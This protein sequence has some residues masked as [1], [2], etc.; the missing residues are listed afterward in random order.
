MPR[1]PVV[2]LTS[3]IDDM[4]K[5]CGDR[6]R[7]FAVGPVGAG[8]LPIQVR[9]GESLLTTPFERPRKLTEGCPS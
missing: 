1:C 4:S 5:L 6:V 9:G 3:D 8:G 2:M 7:L